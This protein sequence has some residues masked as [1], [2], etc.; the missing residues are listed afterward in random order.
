[1]YD[2]SCSRLYLPV[3]PLTVDADG[4]AARRRPHGRHVAGARHDA[5]EPRPILLAPHRLRV[6]AH[7]DAAARPAAVALGERDVSRL[8]SGPGT[9]TPVDVRSGLHLL[10][11][12]RR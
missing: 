1:M 3:R 7:D 6:G 10:D 5:L 4:F 2:R 9:A 12:T 11:A 8:Q